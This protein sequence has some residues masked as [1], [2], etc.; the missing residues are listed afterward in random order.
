LREDCLLKSGIG[1]ASD[2]V[3]SHRTQI[4]DHIYYGRTRLDTNFIENPIRPPA[5]GKKNWLFIGHPEAGLRS[6]IIYSIVVSCQRLGIDALAYM[7]DVLS[8]LHKMTKKN[9]ILALVPSCRK[10]V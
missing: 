7:R 9:N 5:L 4:K 10:P 8:R 2:Y 3:L 6:A 1:K